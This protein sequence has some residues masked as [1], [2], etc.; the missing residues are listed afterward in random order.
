MISFLRK[1]LLGWWSQKLIL[2]LGTNSRIGSCAERERKS[3]KVCQA[4]QIWTQLA[5]PCASCCLKYIWKIVNT[6]CHCCS[7][8]QSI[9]WFLT[10][11]SACLIS[12]SLFLSLSFKT[13]K[14]VFPRS[15]HRTFTLVYFEGHFRST[16]IPPTKEAG[17]YVYSLRVGVREIMPTCKS[18]ISY[19]YVSSR[20][21]TWH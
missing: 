16:N 21:H 18:K 15:P 20:P 2:E 4:F 6:I 17:S 13:L 11:F 12:L 8:W 3:T 1:I 7:C 10:C 19:K 5:L 14:W 9:N